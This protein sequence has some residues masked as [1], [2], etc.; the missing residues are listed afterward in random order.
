[1]AS[2]RAEV[3]W[4]RPRGIR[5]IHVVAALSALLAL[6]SV[7]GMF[8]QFGASEGSQVTSDRRLV[9]SIDLRIA[10]PAEAFAT[11]EAEARKAIE[12]GGLLKLQRL[13][14]ADKPPAKVDDA[15]AERL[16]RQHG[17]VWVDMGKTT[18]KKSGYAA[19]YNHV[20]QAEIERRHGAEFLDRL[21]RGEDPVAPA[22][23]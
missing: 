5:A 20:V 21:L 13:D 15:R 18:L 6:G 3:R 7:L 8:N 16:R 11:G 23:P 19:G 4:H 17:I 10:N 22:A 1:M 14:V 12:A 9:A 2:E